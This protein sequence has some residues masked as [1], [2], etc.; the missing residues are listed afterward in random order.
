MYLFIYFYL[1]TLAFLRP[2]NVQ[3]TSVSTL[4][5]IMFGIAAPASSP[6]YNPTNK[7]GLKLI[8]GS[9]FKKQGLLAMAGLFLCKKANVGLPAS[10]KLVPNDG[11]GKSPLI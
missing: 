6:G 4:K 2:L 9:S 8:A 1:T 3:T 10:V 5:L 7:V 11:S